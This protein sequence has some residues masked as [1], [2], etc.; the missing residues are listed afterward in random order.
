MELSYYVSS[1]VLHPEKKNRVS[2]SNP[3]DQHIKLKE[4]IL[5]FG[6]KTYVKG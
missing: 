2:V 1:I 6:A 5:T 3:N 4:L